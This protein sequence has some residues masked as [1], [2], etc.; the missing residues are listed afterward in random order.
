MNLETIVELNGQS[1]DLSDM[2]YVQKLEKQAYDNYGMY[3]KYGVKIH[4]YNVKPT[5]IWF[6][7]DL[8]ER[9]RAFSLLIQIMNK[10]KSRR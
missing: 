3:Y 5:T 4:F 8:N 6:S 1:Y 9:N 10:V 2:K 7:N